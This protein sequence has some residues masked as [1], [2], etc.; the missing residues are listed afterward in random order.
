MVALGGWAREVGW[1]AGWLRYRTRVVELDGWMGWMGGKCEPGQPGGSGWGWLSH[2]T[3]LCCCLGVTSR[4]GVA[5]ARRRRF[6]F[7]CFGSET[8]FRRGA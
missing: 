2:E 5:S 1:L 7:R 8:A 6:R 3:M 4:I